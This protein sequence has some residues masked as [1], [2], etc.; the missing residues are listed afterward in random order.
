MVARD[1]VEVGEVFS[2]NRVSVWVGGK[3][4]KMDGGDVCP[5][6]GTY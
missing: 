6:V 2:G 1:L 5:T 3:V 4:L